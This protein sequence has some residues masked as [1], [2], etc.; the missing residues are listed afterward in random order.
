MGDRPGANWLH[1]PACPRT[2]L[3]TGS[4]FGG[5]CHTGGLGWVGTGMGSPLW[6]YPI[7]GTVLGSGGSRPVRTVGEGALIT[8]EDLLWVAEEWEKRGVG[9]SFNPEVFNVTGILDWMA[10]EQRIK[11]LL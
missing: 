7:I 6:K 4:G 11:L 9:K 1:A 2:L 3:T 8:A 5:K 10:L